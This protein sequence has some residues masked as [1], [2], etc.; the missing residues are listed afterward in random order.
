MEEEVQEQE[1]IKSKLIR[2]VVLILVLLLMVMLIFTFIQGDTDKAFLEVLMGNDKSVA[3]KIAG[4]KISTDYFYAAKKICVERYRERIPGL[5]D[6]TNTLNSCAFSTIRTLKIDK[7]IATNVGYSIS[8]LI[9]KQNISEESRKSYKA[10]TESRGAGYA[11]E[12]RISL[13]ELYSRNL[14]YIPMNFRQDLIISSSL[15]DGFLYS[16]VKETEDE[17]KVKLEFD[18]TKISLSYISFSDEDLSKLIGTDFPVT[19]EEIK[20][21]YDDSV[22]NKSLPL[23]QDGKPLSLDSRKPV[24]L[25][26]LREEKK[27]VKLSEVKSKI[28]SSKQDPNSNLLT[29]SKIA[30]VPVQNLSNISFSNLDSKDKQANFLGNSILLKDMTKI[31]FGKGRIGGPYTDKNQIIYVEFKELKFDSNPIAKK[32]NPI[33]PNIS[34][35]RMF[36]YEIHQAVSGNFPIERSKSLAV[37]G[38]P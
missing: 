15:A 7:Y 34:K 16:E 38:E 22:K 37:Q 14:N 5:A 2:F 13:N 23:D 28:L 3:G 29:L 19:E 25:N 12:E 32:E 31:P 8:E 26:K 4:E 1:T 11:D 33:D 20:K 35:I 21:E 36:I 17:K 9:I 6:D 30:N 27:Q 10:L 24:I 18:S